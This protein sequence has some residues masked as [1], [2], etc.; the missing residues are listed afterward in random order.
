[1][2]DSFLDV[3]TQSMNSPTAES[4]EGQQPNARSSAAKVAILLATYNGERFLG[5]QLESFQRQHHTNWCV[6]ASDD[7]SADSTPN[8]LKEWGAKVGIERLHVLRG[9]SQGSSK[10]FLSMVHNTGIRADYYAYS[11]QDDVWEDDK[12]T[13]AVEWLSAQPSNEPALYCTRTRLV[14]EAGRE[15]GVSELFSRPP[16][17]ANALMQNITGGNTMVFNDAARQLLLEVPATQP[18]VIHDWWTYI[19]VSA[20][21]GAICF[22]PYPSVRYRQHGANLIGM[23]VEGPSWSSRIRKLFTQEFRRNGDLNVAALTYLR[24]KFSPEAERIFSLYAEAR[25]RWL[26]P[27]VL[28]VRR[29]GLYRLTRMGDLGLLAAVVMNKL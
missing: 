3:V 1:M 21:G 25:Q 6:W 29:A 15:L 23:S 7:G 22:D 18:L 20:V 9:P 28:G 11:D 8:I 27:R 5:E 2:P 12:L 10:N 24:P 19:V 16:S 14:D 26:V 4:S 17:F 13:R